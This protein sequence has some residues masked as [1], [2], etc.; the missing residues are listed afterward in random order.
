MLFGEDKAEKIMILMPIVFGTLKFISNGGVRWTK[1]WRKAREARKGVDD[2]AD[3][4][5][6]S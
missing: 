6:P 4:K 3:Q 2:P 1:S 5:E